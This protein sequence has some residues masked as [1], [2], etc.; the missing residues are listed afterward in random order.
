MELERQQMMVNDTTDGVHFALV[1]MGGFVNL[2]EMTADQRRHMYQQEA[3]NLLASRVMGQQR[4]L[5]VVRHQNQGIAA[6]QD[7]DET[8]EHGEEEEPEN[9]P[10]SP[11]VENDQEGPITTVVVALRLCG[12]K[13]TMHWRGLIF[14]M[15]LISNTWSCFCWVT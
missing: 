7:T 8:M 3:G 5:Q 6:G 1:Q 4:F 10:V 2:T 15:Q 13:S 11:V 9:D 14:E 12:M